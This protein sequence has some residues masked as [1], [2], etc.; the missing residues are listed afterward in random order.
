MGGLLTFPRFSNA[1]FMIKNI[2][3]FCK[4][5]HLRINQQTK[6]LKVVAFKYFS[7]PEKD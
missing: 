4:S 7:A 2:F 1:T 6:S 5:L 3:N